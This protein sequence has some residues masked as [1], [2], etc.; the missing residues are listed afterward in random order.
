MFGN[1]DKAFAFDSRML[2]MRAY[3]QEVL[4]SNIA[5][6]DTPNY[7]AM[8]VDFSSVLGSTLEGVTL[9]RTNSRHLETKG[10]GVAG[11]VPKYRTSVQPSIDGNT[12]DTDRE[13]AAYAENALQYMFALQQLNGTIQDT[14]LVLKGDK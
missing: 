13:Q 14:L 3:R 12:V 8:D 5:N 2:S 6:A 9:A 4:A 1:I 7:K 11:V 10:S